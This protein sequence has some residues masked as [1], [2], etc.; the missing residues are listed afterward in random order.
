MVTAINKNGRAAAAATAPVT[1]KGEQLLPSWAV[2]PCAQ[3]PLVVGVCQ[4]SALSL[5]CKTPAA[6]HIISLPLHSPLAE[7]P[8]TRP[9]IAAISGADSTVATN[10]VTT[11]TISLSVLK[12]SAGGWGVLGGFAEAWAPGC[13]LWVGLLTP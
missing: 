7:V 9:A 11:Q 4:P 8:P 12:P 6:C 1:V 13:R 3:W 5:R 2:A 10:G